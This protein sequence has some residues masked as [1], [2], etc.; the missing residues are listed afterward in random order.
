[1]C[2]RALIASAI[3]CQLS[4]PTSAGAGSIPSTFD[5][6]PYRPYVAADTQNF[7]N[8]PTLRILVIGTGVN[9][10][11][12][13]AGPGAPVVT[14]VDPGKNSR[15]YTGTTSSDIAA[16]ATVYRAD[17][18]RIDS[19]AI[20]SLTAHT[21][22]SSIAYR[23]AL[24][25]A[26]N[27]A[28]QYDAI[29]FDFDPAYYN[30]R[31]HNL[32]AGNDGVSPGSLE[33]VQHELSSDP[34][35]PYDAASG[36]ANLQHPEWGPLTSNSL[37]A[38]A[39]YRFQDPALRSESRALFNYTQYGKNDP[40]D[41]V[42]SLTGQLQALGIPMIAPAGDH[43][44]GWQSV[45]GI[46]SLD[47]VI[48]VGA[49]AG[50]GAS[51]DRGWQVAPYSSR[52]I[53]HFGGAKPDLLAPGSM[54]VA[55]ATDS[56]LYR[57]ACGNDQAVAATLAVPYVCRFDPA[58]GTT[59]S[60]AVD[61]V[62]PYQPARA[63][64][65]TP[66]LGQASSEAAAALV[67][68][69]AAQLRHTW[70]SGCALPAPAALGMV[71]RSVLQSRARVLTAAGADGNV[72]DPVTQG[73]GVLTGFPTTS[74]ACAGAHPAGSL[75]PPAAP[76]RGEGGSRTVALYNPS[77]APVSARNQT[78]DQ[79]LG[80][81]GGSLQALPFAGGEP[82][83]VDASGDHADI[84]AAL[85]VQYAGI[86][87]GWTVIASA[88]QSAS[89]PYC[90]V[91]TLDLALHAYYPATRPVAN[92]TFTLEAMNAAPGVNP[93][94]VTGFNGGALPVPSGFAIWSGVTGPS[95]DTVLHN[96]LPG[97][98]QLKLWGDY[99]VEAALGT[100][101][102]GGTVNYAVRELGHPVDYEVMDL[103]VAS[104]LPCPD[105]TPAQL[106]N[107]L[108][109]CRPSTAQWQA[110]GGQVQRDSQ[111][112]QENLPHVSVAFVCGEVSFAV[113]PS[114]SSQQVHNLSCSDFRLQSATVNATGEGAAP[115]SLP[116]LLGGAESTT[117]ACGGSAGGW[118]WSS[119]PAAGD[120]PAAHLV[121]D[122]NPTPAPSTQPIV[123]GIAH[124]P[125]T[126]PGPNFKAHLDVNLN[127]VVQNAAV[128]LVSTIGTE[129]RTAFIA[130]S[131]IPA[132]QPVP[133]GVTVSSWGDPDW[134]NVNAGFPSRG[135]TAQ[136]SVSTYWDFVPDHTYRGDL[137]LV[138]IPTTTSPV[139]IDI[140]YLTVQLQTW[141]NTGYSHADWLSAAPGFQSCSTGACYTTQ[142][143]SSLD[144]PVNPGFCRTP[145][146]TMAGHSVSV[147]E[148]DDLRMYVSTPLGLDP[149]Q[150]DAPMGMR[151]VVPASGSC[152][153]SAP[154]S[155]AAWNPARGTQLFQGFVPFVDDEVEQG[156]PIMDNLNHGSVN[157]QY[158]GVEVV[159][160]DALNRAS[161]CG[162]TVYADYA[163]PAS[164]TGLP[165]TAP[166]QSGLQ[167][168]RQDVLALEGFD[169]SVSVT[170]SQPSL[171]SPNPCTVAR[172]G[173]RGAFWG[174]VVDSNMIPC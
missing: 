82:V 61:G 67:T 11:A 14:L 94:E 8:A 28:S 132:T 53:T 75:S 162:G 95:G 47:S 44:P 143:F 93:L 52:G 152:S 80:D 120:D 141:G 160:A 87:C 25:Y 50:G 170:N 18:L 100:T 4:A 165:T 45:I 104:P 115:Q 119:G 49:A 73:A 12:V 113:G 102:A 88:G 16:M 74:D 155:A 109:A 17:R 125:F 78:T 30:D 63:G 13:P 133:G 136:G 85:P 112:C 135:G 89:I 29:L 55:A 3:L 146:R 114:V 57:A 139:H 118:T 144:Q 72:P 106:Y 83:Q 38:I 168:T 130:D 103:V 111:L 153:A 147:T 127:Y 121:A 140:S 56:L 86:D 161:A 35:A 116:A 51:A 110:S 34:V 151:A 7:Q 10:D 145:V 167:F 77:G 131:A 101:D 27:H 107:P 70:S 142:F 81:Q 62:L 169:A 174:V 166:V 126:L 19:Y 150:D 15:D 39:P 54:T 154:V 173:T 92:D 122:F 9:P 48:T 138:A 84:T 36:Q 171:Q 96:V 156:V 148:C 6:A 37:D 23:G 64:I 66:A 71:I 20:E 158:A 137:Y 117:P 91:R 108:P 32:L 134:N 124:H 90:S 40:W 97:W 5:A 123:V 69:E 105:G 159:G 43:G 149:T 41:D 157:G 98:Y 164:G 59:P 76:A 68:V 65:L 129:S 24:Q 58:K 42:V 31:V 46:S 79:F 128:F 172:F 22:T 163:M 1:M 21:G 33:Q 60:V 26:L 99:S 2:S